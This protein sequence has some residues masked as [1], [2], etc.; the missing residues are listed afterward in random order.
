MGTSFRN[1]TFVEI[2]NGENII[3]G[4]RKVDGCRRSIR[5]KAATAD[6]PLIG[7][8]II[9]RKTV[10]FDISC[11]NEFFSNEVAWLQWLHPRVPDLADET[12]L[13]CKINVTMLDL[14]G[15]HLIGIIV[16]K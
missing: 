14:H 11:T 1:S 4:S 16:P 8:G 6:V 7:S 2:S 12:L 5:A 3:P 15:I 13:S 10:K 9:E